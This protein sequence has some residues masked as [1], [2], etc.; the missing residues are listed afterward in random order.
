MLPKPL[1]K[2][3]VISHLVF[4]LCYNF[5]FIHVSIV[6]YPDVVIWAVVDTCFPVLF[7]WHMGYI[8]TSSL[9]VCSR[10]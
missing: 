10:R 4:N 5:F 2:N 3:P 6:R 7:L 8:R 1:R 9:F